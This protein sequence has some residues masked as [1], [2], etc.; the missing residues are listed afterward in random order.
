VKLGLLLG[1]M[2]GT[3]YA[4]AGTGTAGTKNGNG[5]GTGTT[6]TAGS[7]GSQRIA[8][9]PDIH[10]LIVGDPGLGKSQLL[11][12]AANVSPRSVVITGNTATTAGLTVAVTREGKNDMSLE[13]GALV[14]ADRGVCC[15]DELDKMSCDP[16]S[17]LE[18]MEQQSIS[19]AKAGTVTS[20]R[21]RTTVLAAA[22]PVS[23]SLSLSLILRFRF[24]GLFS[25]YSGGIFCI[26][27]LE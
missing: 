27:C 18:A 25:L 19:V 8:V 9:R 6:S 14:L 16:H 13:A 15:I 23:L 1:L 2:G 17:L 12:A 24:K 22:N 4:A 11:R 5:N 7:R 20:I 21:C 26:V 3:A 10:V